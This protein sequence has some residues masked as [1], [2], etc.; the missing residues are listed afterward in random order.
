MKQDRQ[1]VRASEDFI[2]ADLSAGAV[3]VLFLLAAAAQAGGGNTALISN[4]RIAERTGLTNISRLIKELYAA[5]AITQRVERFKNNRR[6]CNAY[7]LSDVIA[8]P[9]R[10]ALVPV[11]AVE[12]P[13]SCLRLFILYCVHANE[14]GRCLLSLSM[15]QE[16]S[17][18]AR[19][20]IISCCKLLAERGFI[21]K[22]RYLCRE[23]DYGYN[24]IYIT[25]MLRRRSTRRAETFRVA[26]NAAELAY[27]SKCAAERFIAGEPIERLLRIMRQL[28]RSTRVADFIRDIFRR[29]RTAVFF[30]KK[31]GSQKKITRNINIQPVLI[32]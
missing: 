30:C 24:R 29:L 9:K 15:I 18:M 20:T 25:H 1:L 2:R 10:Y 26:V 23:G 32:I 4:A 3:K 14:N 5:G 21:A 16:L 11:S 19:G 8:S 12:L 22:Q 7:V 13:K 6:R 31:T 28:F 17:G 27:E